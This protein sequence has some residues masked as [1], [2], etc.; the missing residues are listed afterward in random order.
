MVNKKNLITLIFLFF[1][2]SFYGQNTL[3]G[4][5]TDAETN[6]AIIGCNVIL[7]G[8][9]IGTTTD[10]NGNYTLKNIPNGTYNIIYSYISYEK[11]MQKIQVAAGDPVTNNVKLKMASTQMKDVVVTGTRRTDTELS[12]L[13]T[14]K[15][16]ALTVNGISSQQI[17]KSQDRDAS[18]VIRR[19]PGVSIRDGKFVVVRGL[20]ERYNSVW[21]NGSTTPSSESDVRAFSF[22]V[23]PSGQ[24][25]NILIYKS[26]A[27]ELPADFA[28]AMINIKTKSLIDKNS[29]SFSYSY[30]NRQGTTGLDFYTY[31]GGK[32]DWLGFDDGTRGV[33]TAVPTTEEY[34]KL[35]D[36]TTPEKITQINSISKSFNTIMTPYKTTAQPDGDF[37]L[38]MNGRFTLGSVSIGSITALGYNSTNTTENAYRAAYWSYPDTSF[39][40]MQ[41]AYISRVRANGLSNWSFNFANNQKIEFRNLFNNNGMTRTILKEGYDFYTQTNE[42]SY[43]LTYESRTTY[44]GQLAG[45]HPLYHDLINLD[46]VVGYSFADKK[47]PDIRR[48]KTSSYDNEPESQFMSNLSSQVSSDVLGRMS[49]E[50]NENIINGALNYSHKIRMGS[51]TPEIKTGVYYEKKNRDF[52]SRVFG[53][54][55]SGL[56][57]MYYFP[58]ESFNGKAGF[59]DA[60]FKSIDSIFL[61][62]IDYK[63]GMVMSEATQKADSYSANNELMAG[64]LAVNLPMSKWVNAYM[65]VRVEKNKLQLNGYK[66]DGTDKNPIGVKIDSINIFP[67]INATV[68]FTDKLLLRMSSG[69]TVNRPEFREVS[70]FVFYNFEENI[71]TYG[72]PNVV[73]C[74][75]NNYD[76]RF[77]WYPTSEEIVSIGA[78]YKD[79]QNPIESKILNTGSGWNYTFENGKSATSY[80]AELDIRKRLHEFEGAG[81]FKFISNFTFVVNASLIKS[82]IQTDSVTES[83]TE[84]P[85]QGQSPYIINFGAYYNDNKSKFMTSLMYNKT[86]E[87]IAIVGDKNIPHIYE[88]PFNSLDFSIEKGITKWINLRFGIKNILDNAIVFQQ[89]Q[90]YKDA[91]VPKVREQVTSKFKPGTQF[92]LSISV[93]L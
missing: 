15:L 36:K 13:M 8:T 70:P 83:A 41:K 39:R 33:P 37:Q 28:G 38:A 29:I 40:F 24:I 46:W 67:S 51:F 22:D 3:Q 58:V 84:R 44:S 6:E 65:G 49:L 68:N 85:L 88:M 42:R 7:Q 86:G 9:T 48:V 63:T 55:K 47:Q 77:E 10:L 53:Y 93:N 54:V 56:S 25:D 73:S 57:N 78:F 2:I 17:S 91:G 27:P 72:N 16:S 75:I 79:F 43:E 23:I 90:E 35:F 61:N 5:I 89:F 14:S 82:V 50:N 74:Y 71:I 26:P 66:R 18:E 19:V 45:T 1:V 32:S 4:L 52:Y 59:D 31:K 34:K 11:K 76:T 64:Y 21:L 81:L 92:K 12:L 60:M 80:G 30:G 20:T 87:R 69:K 62:K